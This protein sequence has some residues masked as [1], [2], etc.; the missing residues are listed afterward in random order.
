MVDTNDNKLQARVLSVRFGSGELDFLSQAAETAGYSIGQAVR[1]CVL[2]RMR[3]KAAGS[4]EKL[5]ELI[6][7]TKQGFG[8]VIE[9]LD[10]EK[11]EM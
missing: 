8:I 7:L 2:S 9:K 10:A 6:E 3:A 11:C 5:A 4:D 1:D